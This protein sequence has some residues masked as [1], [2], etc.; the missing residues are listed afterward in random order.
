M[1]RA[2]LLH[3]LFCLAMAAS[4]H[5]H[6]SHPAPPEHPCHAD[7]VHHAR[8]TCP[9][10]PP[11]LPPPSLCDVILVPQ[12]PAPPQACWAQLGWPAVF[13]NRFPGV[14]VPTH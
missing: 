8:P 3:M 10:T 13:E 5:H 12:M 6:G 14:P 4:F 1:T 9:P 2:K 7:R 11:V